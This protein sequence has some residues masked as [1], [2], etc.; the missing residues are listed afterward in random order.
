FPTPRSSDLEAFISFFSESFISN[1]IIFG[2]HCLFINVGVHHRS[3][4]ITIAECL[5]QVIFILKL[6]DR[7]A[8]E[9]ETT[10]NQWFHSLPRNLLKSINIDCGKMFPIGSRSVICMVSLFTL[11]ILEHLPNVS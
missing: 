9:N 5:S 6:K 7:K 4:A 2:T 1:S 10:M 8:K 11:Q 3:A